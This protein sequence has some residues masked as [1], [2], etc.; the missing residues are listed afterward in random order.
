[1]NLRHSEANLLNN[2]PSNSNMNEVTL[3]E[4]SINH[5][6]NPHNNLLQMDNDGELE[7]L[8][9]APSAQFNQDFLSEISPKK[10]TKSKFCNKGT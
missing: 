2:E 3:N 9:H 5:I 10:R 4:Q 6:E 7:E 8:M 1:M